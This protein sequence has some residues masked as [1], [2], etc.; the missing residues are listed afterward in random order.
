M[1]KDTIEQ[2]IYRTWDKVDWVLMIAQSTLLHFLVY[3][4][5]GGKV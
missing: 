1:K 3:L 4:L 5:L 2:T